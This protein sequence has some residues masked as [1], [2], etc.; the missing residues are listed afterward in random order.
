VI[1]CVSNYA[2]LFLVQ[3]TCDFLYITGDSCVLCF[4]GPSAIDLE[5]QTGICQFLVSA[6]Y[7]QWLPDTCWLLRENSYWKQ[8][9]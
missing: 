2:D 7:L 8:G 9:R 6:D 5:W 3:L 4:W 1:L